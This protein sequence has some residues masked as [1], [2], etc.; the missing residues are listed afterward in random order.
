VRTTGVRT[1]GVRPAPTSEINATTAMPWIVSLA[2]ASSMSASMA[3]SDQP[4]IWLIER[5]GRMK[6]TWLI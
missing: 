6:L 3:D 1:T 2:R 5:F 4:P